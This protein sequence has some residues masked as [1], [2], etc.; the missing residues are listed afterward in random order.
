MTRKLNQF[1]YVCR[2]L[3]PHGVH[4]DFHIE[5]LSDDI[6]RL[7]NLRHAY[8]INPKNEDERYETIISNDK[9]KSL[10]LHSDRINMREDVPKYRFWYI[11]VSR[12]NARNLPEGE[13]F[14][15][16]LISCTVFD[17][18]RGELGKVFD[19]IDNGYQKLYQVKKPGCKDLYFPASENI[20]LSTDIE[21]AVIN[22]DLPK[23]LYEIYRED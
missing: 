6:E 4:G 23:G 13:Y 14:I 16:D 20:I 22:V 11:A 19:I 2:I 18:E 12:E 3:S 17:K 9:Y 7:K 21:A 1:I 10:I 15:C 8:I 5:L